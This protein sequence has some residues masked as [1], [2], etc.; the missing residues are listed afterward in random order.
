MSSWQEWIVGI[1]IVLCIA[2][3]VYSI[4]LFFRRARENKS[5]CTTCV[6][7]CELKDMMDRKRKECQTK[8]K[9]AKKKCCG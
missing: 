3:M 7:G 4:F 1:L 8:K 6:S 9:S 5:P 2:R